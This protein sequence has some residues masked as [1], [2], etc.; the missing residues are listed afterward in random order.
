MLWHKLSAEFQWL[1]FYL[2]ICRFRRINEIYGQRVGDQI[3]AVLG[4]RFAENKRGTDTYAYLGGDLFA[5]IQVGIH[6]LSGAEALATRVL[7]I[8]REPIEFEGAIFELDA[9]IG[10]AFAPD[11]GTFADVIDTKANAALNSAKDI[12]A[13]MFMFYESCVNRLQL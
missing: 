9:C 10:I 2:D 3:L 12:G 5:I 13:G 8:V 6:D 7:R 4:E 11:N 1:C